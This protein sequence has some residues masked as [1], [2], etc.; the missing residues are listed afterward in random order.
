MKK[1]LSGLL[2]VLTLSFLTV[3]VVS[4]TRINESDKISTKDKKPKTKKPKKPK[5]PRGGRGVPPVK[6]GAIVFGPK[7]IPKTTLVDPKETYAT[8]TPA[9]DLDV[10][11][12]ASNPTVA[13]PI[14]LAFGPRGR[15]W[16]TQY[17]QYPFP[18]G[19]KIIGTDRY[20]RAVYD[21]VTPPPPNHFKGRDRVTILEDTDGDGV[22]DKSKD[23]VDTLNLATAALP[24]KDGVWVMMVPYLLFYPDANHDDVPDGPP[25][26]HLS[27]F[28]L[29]DTHAVASSLTWGP[30]GWIYG[31]QGST[32][33]ATVKRPGLDEKGIHF[34]GHCIWRYH[35]Q[36]REFEVF[37]EGGG[38]TF[39]VAFNAQGQLFSGCN[40]GKF[41]Y[42]YA[43]GAGFRKN[44]I[45]HGPH[46]NPYSYGEIPCMKTDNLPN[47]KLSQPT[48]IYEGH[49]FPKKYKGTMFT[50]RLLTRHV[51]SGVLDSNG[52]TFS[53]K[54]LPTPLIGHDVSF[55]P[56]VLTDAPDGSIYLG[57]WWDPSI[58]HKGT[59]E[60]TTHKTGRIY[61][62]RA[63]GLKPEAPVDF[64]KMSEKQLLDN[65]KHPNKWRRWT[66]MRLLAD[67]E[68]TDV[69]PTL[70]KWITQE[71]GRL[72]LDAL[73]AYNLIDG[74]DEALRLQAM[75]HVNPWVRFWGVRFVGDQRVCSKAETAQLQ[76]MA[77]EE[78]DA[79]VR[80]QLASTMKRL[81][82]ATVLPML[83]EMLLNPAALTDPFLPM[84][85]WWAT[86]QQ[87]RNDLNGVVALYKN[88]AIWKSQI[89]TETILPRLVRKA[90]EIQQK[91]YFTAI[92][93]IYQAAP[94]AGKTMIAK[95]FTKYYG[96]QIASLPKQLKAWVSKVRN[97]LPGG[98]WATELRSGNK[99]HLKQ[100]IDRVMAKK[101]PVAERIALLEAIASKQYPTALPK[102]LELSGRSGTREPPKVLI[103]SL[104]AVSAY[105]KKEVYENVKKILIRPFQ[106]TTVRL[107]R[108]ETLL[109]RKSWAENYLNDVIASKIPKESDPV[110]LQKVRS[111]GDKKLLALAKKVW[112][113]Q[114]GLTNAKAEAELT[115]LLKMIEKTP[116]K[117]ADGK[118]VYM[119]HCA[120]C[121]SLKDVKKSDY[122]PNLTGYE[123]GNARYFL[124]NILLPNS[125]IR[126][127]YT[128]MAIEMKNGSS[129][130]GIVINQNNVQLVLKTKPGVTKI[131]RKR[132][133]LN[134]RRLP[135]SP[136]TS[137]ILKTLKDQE[138]SDLLEFIRAK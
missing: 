1:V 35:P 57:D 119:K 114:F 3:A 63:K 82:A 115:R 137:G 111:Y 94:Q 122:G 71:K 77:K 43:Q 116:G 45:K 135:I 136:M 83:P 11:L 89:A 76:K 16:V 61:R 124:S 42:H 27:G 90:A 5:K 17:R 81:P 48:T 92:E 29:E 52:S 120:T 40:G 49:T 75:R 99:S 23:F 69:L 123:R 86:E 53:A 102:I 37:G 26:V 79:H 47:S 98:A 19:V 131:I 20:A 74:L 30:D 84:M 41:G 34:K 33:T 13:Q 121:H 60:K 68:A 2:V 101:V 67:Q 113:L 10:D 44:W 97:Q 108:H 70:K 24:G 117:A 80:G 9:S 55:R 12:I 134:M 95:E 58:N 128:Q 107:A 126:A 103:A 100:A 15:L 96:G 18:A 72:A 118:A 22:Y 21:K 138:I 28:G 51:Q 54:G 125:F 62:L 8:L 91:S 78:K 104:E 4:A 85:L 109:S 66:A 7:N 93:T 36:T 88:Q 130:V 73:W 87:T 65:L 127:G 59:L 39:A 106:D 38:N 6:E 64:T 110:L 46:M 105:D 129:N 133:I 32:C 25:T 132:D 56:V 14:H 112:P 31:A 50:A